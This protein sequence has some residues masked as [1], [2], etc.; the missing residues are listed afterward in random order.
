LADISASA[1]LG[2][3]KGVMADLKRLKL[4]A[5]SDD[6]PLGFKNAKLKIAGNTMTVDLE[7]KLATTLVFIPITFMVTQVT[8][9][10][11]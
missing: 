1:A 8:Q 9:V 5:P 2:F 4:T 10:A 7:I 3:L 11:A 6:A